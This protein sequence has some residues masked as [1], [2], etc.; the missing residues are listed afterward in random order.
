[1]GLGALGTIGLRAP[2][3]VLQGMR[4]MVQYGLLIR[5]GS[6]EGGGL[7]IKRFLQWIEHKG[8]GYWGLGLDYVV[9]MIYGVRFMLRLEHRGQSGFRA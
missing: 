3:R 1:M 6:S 9:S 7:S 2:V 8:F 5:V 4:Y